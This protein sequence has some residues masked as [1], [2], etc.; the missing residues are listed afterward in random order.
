MR[1]LEKY[2]HQQQNDFNPDFSKTLHLIRQLYEK[3]ES[4][5][6]F[7]RVVA[8]KYG[9]FIISENIF[10]D[11]DIKFWSNQVVLPPAE[12]Y[13]SDD[14][15]YGEHLANGYYLAVKKTISFSDINN[16]VLVYAMIPVESDFFIETDYLPQRFSYSQYCCKPGNDQR[17]ANRFSC[18]ALKR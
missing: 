16:R 1:L 10:D 13:A 7:D 14:G 11:A 18:S 5:K 4:L 12:T 3:K 15:E 6:D 8:K 2:L 17:F 9:I